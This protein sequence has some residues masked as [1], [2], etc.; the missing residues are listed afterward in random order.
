MELASRRDGETLCRFLLKMSEPSR[1]RKESHDLT[2]L[3]HFGRSEVKFSTRGFMPALQTIFAKK[4]GSLA[5]SP[6]ILEPL[7]SR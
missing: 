4:G 2:M 1:G 6:A 5:T 3:F 7:V